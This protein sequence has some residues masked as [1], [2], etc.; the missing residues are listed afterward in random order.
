MAAMNFSIMDAYGYYERR[1]IDIGRSLNRSVIAWQDIAGFPQNFSNNYNDY[2]DVTL[3][4][5]A[6]CY[7]GDWQ[8]DVASFTQQNMSV[9]I[10]GPFYITQQNGAPTTPHFTWQQMYM[11]DLYNFTGGNV[12]AQQQYVK[13]GE[14]CAWDDAAET[15]GG[16]IV[17]GL[18]PYLFGVSEAWWSPQAFTSGTQPDEARAHVH[19]CRTVARGIPSHPVYYFGNYCPLEYEV[20]AQP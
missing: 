17:V 11:T 14:L 2:P 5:W 6:G 13:G 16:D 18:S 9:I 20:P 10:S 4:V 8:A 3:D 12:T 1:M 19:R 7:S 15:D